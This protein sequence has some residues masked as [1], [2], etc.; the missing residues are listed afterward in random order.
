MQGT[1]FAHSYEFPTG[2]SNRRGWKDSFCPGLKV[3]ADFIG[4]YGIIQSHESIIFRFSG[5]EDEAAILVCQEISSSG[6]ATNSLNFKKPAPSKLFLDV[7]KVEKKWEEWPLKTAHSDCLFRFQ[8]VHQAKWKMI[9]LKQEQSKS[10]K[11]VCS[12]VLERGRFLL[13]NV[14]P[15]FKVSSLK[16][17]CWK[18]FVNN[19]YFRPNSVPNHLIFWRSHHRS[20]WESKE[21]CEN[22]SRT[23]LAVFTGLRICLMFLSKAKTYSSGM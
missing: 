6:T 23:S 1:K 22:G 11:E 13:T 3:W 17:S 19:P 2:T 12:G 14:K 16:D 20:N 9:R 18:S 15:Y 21:L 4:N 8:A 10:Y 7:L 5:L